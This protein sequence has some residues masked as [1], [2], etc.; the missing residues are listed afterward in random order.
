M[1][2]PC[3]AVHVQ[4]LAIRVDDQAIAQ[5]IEG[6]IATRVRFGPGQQRPDPNTTAIGNTFTDAHISEAAIG[7]VVAQHINRAVRADSEALYTTGKTMIRG[8]INFC[9]GRARTRL[10]VEL[11]NITIDLKKIELVIPRVLG[12]ADI[13]AVVRGIKHQP[14]LEVGIDS[15]WRSLDFDA[16]QEPGG[17]NAQPKHKAE[18]ELHLIK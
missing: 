6:G 11:V 16:S 17:K 10:Q 15:D 13:L 14:N 9:G 18:A 3:A 5:V 4:V 2:G 8:A 7:G 12:N 1:V